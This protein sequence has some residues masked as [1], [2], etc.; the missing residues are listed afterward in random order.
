[1]M[2]TLLI[3]LRRILL[4]SSIRVDLLPLPLMKVL[5]IKV[6][7]KKKKLEETIGLKNRKIVATAKG[8]GKKTTICHWYAS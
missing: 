4:L 1:M 8:A 7:R 2:I 5:M 3:T 6:K